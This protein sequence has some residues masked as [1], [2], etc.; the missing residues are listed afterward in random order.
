MLMP[1]DNK[2]S[3]SLNL[4]YDNIQLYHENE[5]IRAGNSIENLDKTNSLDKWT[6]Y[7]TWSSIIKI[8]EKHL[9]LIK[10]SK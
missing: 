4:R 7:N 3:I 1:M 6:V 10:E 8:N 2:Y 5:N 9:L